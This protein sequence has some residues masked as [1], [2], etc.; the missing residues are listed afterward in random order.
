VVL[1]NPL[2][3]SRSSAKSTACKCLHVVCILT[4]LVTSRCLHVD[5]LRRTVRLNLVCFFVITIELASCLDISYKL[6]GMVCVVALGA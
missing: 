3:Q 6:A 2:V 4:S 1:G 5:T